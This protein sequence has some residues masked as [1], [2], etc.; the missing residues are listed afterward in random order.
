METLKL[1]TRP[2]VLIL[3]WLLV[4]AYTI[5]QLSTVDRALRGAQASAVASAA[6]RL[7]AHAGSR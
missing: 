7:V 4:S 2:V 6:P 1:A 5:S 3:L